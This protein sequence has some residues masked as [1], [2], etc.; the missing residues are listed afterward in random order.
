MEPPGNP[1][2][3]RGRSRASSGLDDILC[4]GISPTLIRE[5]D[6]RITAQLRKRH[7]VRGDQENDFNL[8]HPADLAQV[9][10]VS[11]RFMTWL[12]LARTVS[13]SLGGCPG[14][15]ALGHGE[16]ELP[17]LPM[18]SRRAPE[19]IGR[20]PAGDQGL[21]SARPGGRSPVGRPESVVQCSWKRRRC[22]RRTVSGVTITRVSL[23]S[24]PR[25]DNPA[26]KSRALRCSL[27]RL[28]LRLYTASWW[29][30]ARGW[31]ASWRWPPQRNGQ[32]RSRWSIVVI[33]K[34]DCLG[35]RAERSTGCRP[36]GVL[37]RE[38]RVAWV[39]WVTPVISQK[40][41]PSF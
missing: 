3:F 17:E 27:D 23:H 40:V 15:G 35:I 24:V 12:S 29:R 31:R 4:S 14:A 22:H 30:Q 33:R 38:K 7:R 39:T 34:R 13:S 6:A 2:R 11:H 26:Q 41:S 5:A 36:D 19:R 10:S 9:R 21:E 20:G 37:A 18:D 25:R 32:R 8:R 16:A 28:A 1:G